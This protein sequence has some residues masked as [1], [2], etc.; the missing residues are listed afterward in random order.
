MT[1]LE[2]KI[3]KNKMLQTQ[4]SHVNKG[5]GSFKKILST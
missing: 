5:N 2:T 4:F 3:K 1:T